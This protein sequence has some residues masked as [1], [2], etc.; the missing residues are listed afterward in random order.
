MVPSVFCFR[1][2]CKTLYPVL[3]MIYRATHV[4]WKTEFVACNPN[5]V[6]V[7]PF[8]KSSGLDFLS[9]RLFLISNISRVEYFTYFYIFFDWFVFAMLIFSWNYSIKIISFR[10]VSFGP[11]LFHPTPSS[12]LMFN[13]DYLQLSVTF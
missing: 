11:S 10:N 7:L 3:Y 6:P 13:F 2:S 12:I 4:Y 8:Q 9:F 5:A 1:K